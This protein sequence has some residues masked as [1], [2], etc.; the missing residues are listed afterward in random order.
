MMRDDFDQKIKEQTKEFDD[1]LFSLTEPAFKTINRG[2]A[3]ALLRRRG[4]RRGRLEPDRP[5]RLLVSPGRRTGLRRDT[6]MY[7]LEHGTGQK[8][9]AVLF[10]LFAFLASF[11]IGAAVQA[12]S[13]AEGLSLGF[14]VDPLYRWLGPRTGSWRSAGR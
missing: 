1:F 7:I 13:T 12:N 9:L 10:A 8:W 6:G 2:L 14:G 5:R 4:P 3:G 11:G